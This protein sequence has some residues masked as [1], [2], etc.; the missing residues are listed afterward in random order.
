M[1]AKAALMC[2]TAC[3]V[4]IAAPA[5]AADANTI[6]ELVVTAQKRSESLQSVPA[7]ISAVSGA[8]ISQRGFTSPAQLQFIVPSMAVGK[9]NGVTSITIRGIG[10]NQGSPGVAVHVDGVFQPRATMGDLPQVDMARIE[11]LRGP[12]GTTYGR[13]ATGGVVNYLSAAPTSEMEG[14]VLGSYKSF[15]ESRL[16]GVVN[17]PFGDRVRTRLVLDRTERGKGFVKNVFNGNDGDKGNTLAG[18]L[19]IATDITSDISLDLG[20]NGWHQ[21]GPDTV[22]TVRTLPVP[23]AAGVLPA[24]LTPA[25]IIPARPRQFSADAPIGGSRDYG[26]ASATLTWEAGPFEVR[27]VTGYQR[28][29]ETELA[30]HDSTNI[31]GFQ[32]TRLRRSRSFTEELNLNYTSKRL[33][34]VA[35]VFYMRDNAYDFLNELLTNS[36]IGLPPN[37]KLDFFSFR[38]LTKSRAVFADGTVHVNDNLRLIG[39][40]RWSEDKITQTQRNFIT[41]GNFPP[42]ITCPLQTNTVTYRSTTPRIGAQYDV[43][44]DS[45]LF[46]TYSKGFKSGGFNQYGCKN[47]FRPEKVTSYE[48]GVKNRFFDDSVVLNLSAFYY[49][50]TDL[51][52]SQI[53]G[54]VNLLTNASA[55][56]IKGVELEGAWRPNSYLTLSGNA[57][58][59]DATYRRFE[60]VDQI[61]PARGRQ[62]VAGNRLSNSPKFSTNLGV[63]YRSDPV[64]A[65]G[66]VTA[67]VDLSYRTKVFFREF[68]LPDDTQKAYEILNVALIWDSPDEKYRVRL[69]VDNLTKQEYA[70]FITGSAPDGANIAN[71]GTPRQAGIELRAAF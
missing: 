14:Y 48:M 2:A 5:L 36:Y 3:Q 7:S 60:N 57:A 11:V 10:L 69:F 41:P 71:W 43:S 18:R 24:L 28:F 27:S 1:R 12:Q 13:N 32:A 22:F 19:R 42:I 6:E 30:D 9:Q 51:Q 39:G 29:A 52:L 37:S 56:R 25:A 23:G 70:V 58:L 64:I 68:N 4:L 40:I 34:A 62:N 53:V 67:R 8:D 46:L 17:V 26:S 59:L 44:E 16:Q 15:D 21:E 66:R 55:A 45:N 61:R 38:Y 47:A 65:D 50:Y 49:D 63:A 20:F 33:D 54:T 31:P 35:G